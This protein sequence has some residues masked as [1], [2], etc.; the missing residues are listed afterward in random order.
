MA[1]QRITFIGIG[2]MGNTLAQTLHKAGHSTTI[3]NRTRH[4][5]QVDRVMELGAELEQDAEIAISRSGGPVMVC[6]LD[7]DAIYK[8]PRQGSIVCRE[9]SRQPHQ[10]LHCALYRAPGEPSEHGGNG[11]IAVAASI[12]A[13]VVHT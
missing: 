3:L 7:H 11:G 4:R 5:L 9:N 8:D 6:V 10:R 2:N 12:L 1:L 13:S